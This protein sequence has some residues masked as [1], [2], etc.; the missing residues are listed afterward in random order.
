MTNLALAWLLKCHLTFFYRFPALEHYRG[1][2]VPDS[3][4]FAVYHK[5]LKATTALP[6]VQSALP[7]TQEAIDF[8]SKYASKE[9]TWREP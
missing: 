2:K 1:L 6:S 9:S 8:Y 4:D 7:S 5:W 3:E